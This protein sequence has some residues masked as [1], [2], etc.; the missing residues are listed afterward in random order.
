MLLLLI[1]RIHRLQRVGKNEKN[2]SVNVEP[3]PGLLLHPHQ[4]QGT[5]LY[6]LQV[7]SDEM[8]A[9]GH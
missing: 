7:I 4:T 1:K 8:E 3:G 5:W 6:Y 2:V 9:Q